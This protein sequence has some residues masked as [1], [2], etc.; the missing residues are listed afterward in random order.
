[1][2]GNLNPVDP[3]TRA[4]AEIPATPAL[5]RRYEQNRDAFLEQTRQA[6]VRR[7]AQHLVV[8]SDTPMERLTLD[9]LRRGGLLRN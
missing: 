3:E 2:S 5:L 4:N 7:G 8:A 6:C 9:I 1:M